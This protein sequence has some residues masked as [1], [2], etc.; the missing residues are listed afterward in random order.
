ME[1]SVGFADQRFGWFTHWQLYLMAYG[2]VA[3]G[4]IASLVW[5]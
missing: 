2:A 3:A 1:A 4:G 5:P